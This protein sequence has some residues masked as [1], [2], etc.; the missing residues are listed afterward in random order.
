NECYFPLMRRIR[1]AARGDEAIEGDPKDKIAVIRRTQDEMPRQVFWLSDQFD[2]IEK[3]RVYDA[4]TG[5]GSPEDLALALRLAIR[6]GLVAPN[7]NSLKDYCDKYI[8]LD[9]SAFVCNYAISALGKKYDKANKGATTFRDPASERRERLRDIKAL[10]VLAWAY[11]KHVAIIH[12]VQLDYFAWIA[13]NSADTD[14][15]TLECTVVESNV[16]K[17][18]T[19]S[20]YQILSVDANRVFTVKR[21]DETKV[22]KAYIRPLP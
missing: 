21:P 5:K 22:H 6:F 12:S 13:A 19:H 20:N 11:T 17:G 18:L 10:D 3:Q 7:T 16:V 9:C 1:L 14:V 8:G 4:F 15:S 2:Y